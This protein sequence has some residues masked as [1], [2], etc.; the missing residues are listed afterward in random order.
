MGARLGGASAKK[1]RAVG[2]MAGR[3]RHDVRMIRD[4]SGFP[5]LCKLGTTPGAINTQTAWR[6]RSCPGSFP[7]PLQGSFILPHQSV[8]RESVEVSLESVSPEAGCCRTAVGCMTSEW[9]EA[10][11]HKTADVSGPQLLSSSV[12]IQL[13][14]RREKK[15]ESRLHAGIEQLILAVSLCEKGQEREAL[16]PGYGCEPSTLCG[17]RL[18]RYIGETDRLKCLK[19]FPIRSCR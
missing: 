7:G 12:S 15:S 2:E 5:V 9:Q 10:C 14:R 4:Q 3:G 8:Q 11:E 19:V 13:F 16:R 1:G 18:L 17:R 6:L